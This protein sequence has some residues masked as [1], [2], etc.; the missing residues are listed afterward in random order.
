MLQLLQR[1]LLRLNIVRR[2]TL[3]ERVGIGIEMC[4]GGDKELQRTILGKDRLL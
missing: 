1:G 2:P 4:Q 3:P